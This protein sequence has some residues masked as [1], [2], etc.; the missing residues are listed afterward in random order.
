MIITYTGDDFPYHE[1]PFT[2]MTHWM[3]LADD[4]ICSRCMPSY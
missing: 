2:R 3:Y 1:K 4:V